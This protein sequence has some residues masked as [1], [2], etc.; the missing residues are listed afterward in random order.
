MLLCIDIGNTNIVIGITDKGRI[1][2]H[3]RIRT[4]REATADEMGIL[5]EGLFRSTQAKM[6]DITDIIVSCVVPPLLNTMEDLA[7]IY[8]HIK[9]SILTVGDCIGCISPL[10]IF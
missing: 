6:E 5:I 10:I 3:W 9:L 4:E 2:D 7:R 8:F 1:L